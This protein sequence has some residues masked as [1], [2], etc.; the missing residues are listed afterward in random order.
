MSA[1]VFILAPRALRVSSPESTSAKLYFN[2]RSI[3]SAKGRGTV[4]GRRGPVG[5]P[6]KNGLW[7]SGPASVD[8]PE[9]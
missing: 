9:V 1:S 3:A 5:T 4:P 7:A 6:P 2:P 8:S